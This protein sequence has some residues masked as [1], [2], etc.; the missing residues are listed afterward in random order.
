MEA[1]PTVRLSLSIT[2]I[3]YID[4]L[5]FQSLESAKLRDFKS[6]GI[7]RVSL[8]VQ[9][10]N[11]EDLRYLGRNHSAKDAQAAIALAQSIFDNRVSFDLIYARHTKQTVEDWRQEIKV[12]IDYSDLTILIGC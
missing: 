10:L 4:L 6:A 3:V 8:G 2:A 12:F 7:N 1:N 5:S 9:A 11:D